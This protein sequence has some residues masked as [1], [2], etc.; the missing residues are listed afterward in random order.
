MGFRNN[1]IW[2]E[3][4][5]LSLGRY[6]LCS[7]THNSIGVLHSLLYTGPRVCAYRK[8]CSRTHRPWPGGPRRCR[9]LGPSLFPVTLRDLCFTASRPES[10]I[11]PR[12]SQPRPNHSQFGGAQM[13][14]N[15]H[16]ECKCSFQRVFT[17]RTSFGPYDNPVKT[18]ADIFEDLPWARH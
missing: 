3:N 11:E 14:E 13:Q 2:G 7:Q 12:D 15:N 5:A 6:E 10:G 16:D 9:S 17:Y 8:A 18:T 1:F 4:I